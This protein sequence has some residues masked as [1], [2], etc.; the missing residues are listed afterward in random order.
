M[1]MSKSTLG[2]NIKSKISSV[3][4]KPGDSSYE[5]DVWTA[6]A[7]AIV[8]HIKDE[9][10]IASLTQ[11]GIT[12]SLPSAVTSQGATVSAKGKIS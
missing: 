7:E 11:S 12:V 2:S 1:A 5:L 4:S 6:V 10:E 9:A 8:S 3:T